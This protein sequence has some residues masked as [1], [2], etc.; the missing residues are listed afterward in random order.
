LIVELES[1]RKEFGDL[2]AVDGASFSIKEGEVF[3]LLGPNGA[4]KTTI[5]HMLATLL[6]P[7][8]GRARVNGYDVVREPSKVRK[9][10]GMVFQE[11]SSD[12]LLTGY[13]NLKLHA[14]LYGVPRSIREKR[15]KEVLALVDLSDRRRDLVKHYSGGM[16]RRLEI[17]RGLLHS[18]K[19]LF[20]DEPTLGLD[21]QTREH[22]WHYIEGLVAE[23][24]ISVIITTHYMEEA[25]RLCDRIAIVDHGKVVVLDTPENLKRE[26]GGDIVKLEIEKPDLKAVEVLPYVKKVEVKGSSVFL[27]VE[28]AGAHIQEILSL[29]GKVS[30]VELRPPSLDDVFMHYTGREYKEEGEEGGFWERAMTASERR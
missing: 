11:P 27:T 22:I 12:D 30:T 17:A 16:R 24:K 25:D 28:D 9:S 20:L 29:V 21:P 10:I 14:L 26:L 7:T 5:L 19:V 3:G 15:I 1:L 4:G 2:V 18:P 6:R 13:E 8:G 23:Q